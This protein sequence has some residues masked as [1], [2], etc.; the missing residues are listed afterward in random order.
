MANSSAWFRIQCPTM[1]GVTR[2]LCI[3]RGTVSTQWRF[4][5]S[6]SAGFTG[7]SPGATR[8]PSA[9]DEQLYL[10]TGTDASPSF[11]S[12]FS[13]SL[14]YRNQMAVGGVGE[15]YSFYSITY[16]I[17]D[18]SI[19]NT[20]S[21]GLIMMDKISDP[22]SDDLDGYVFLAARDYTSLFNNGSTAPKTWI[23]KGDVTEAWLGYSAI[24]F[25]RGG[26]QCEDVFG[27][28]AVSG[29]GNILPVLYGR[30]ALETS[31]YC[32]IKGQSTLLNVT[33]VSRPNGAVVSVNSTRDKIQLGK[34]LLPWNGGYSIL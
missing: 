9:T 18:G 12:L 1:G 22:S 28:N 5:Y 10:G 27:V 3:Q 15:G 29:L 24:S 16:P 33:T 4:K 13:T 14:T 6:Y 19:S 20:S 23:K 17:C 21:M 11:T 32:G 8:V 7:G 2:E 31:Q 26:T 25:A 34:Y 30:A